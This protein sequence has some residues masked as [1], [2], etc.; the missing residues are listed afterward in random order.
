MR[1]YRKVDGRRLR[2]DQ[3]R[4]QITEATLRVI[5]REGV[6]GVS[7]RVVAT[8]AGIPPASITYHYAALDD[9]LEA[10]LVESAAELAVEV[11]DLIE[12]TRIKGLSPAGAVAE[13]LAEALGS[14]RGRTMAQYE[15]YLL[16]ARKPALRS[17]ARL[18]L[19]VLT[20]LGRQP[21][22][23]GFRAFLAAVDGVLMQGL[24]DD[25]P[26][27]AAEL[28]PVVEHLLAPLR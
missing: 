24:I 9:L 6:A 21:D 25:E 14:R 2:G 26:P 10:T 23:V 16:A 17:A 20:S 28:L 22:E 27:T 4:R 5:E 13:V 12:S 3:R 8:E 18:W 7:H 15:L 19:D 1:S 11:R